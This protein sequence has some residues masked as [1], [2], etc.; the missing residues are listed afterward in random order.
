MWAGSAG[1]EWFRMASLIGW[2]PQLKLLCQ[3]LG[4]LSLWSLISKKLNWDSWHD[5][6]RV[7]NS[8]REEAPVCDPTVCV[9]L[10]P[11]YIHAIVKAS[12]S[13]TET[14]ELEKQTLQL[15]VKY[16]QHF[17]SLAHLALWL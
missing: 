9:F 1:A 10:H 15:P 4:P 17:L 8:K 2:R 12:H 16:C 13:Q 11:F 5:S 6:P 3:W 7:P 14:Q